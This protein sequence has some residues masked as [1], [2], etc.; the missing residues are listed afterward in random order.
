MMK[1]ERLEFRRFPV[2]GGAVFVST[3]HMPVAQRD[4]L[5]EEYELE[6]VGRRQLIAYIGENTG[7]KRF[8]EERR[9]Y[10]SE[11]R[12][13][14]QDIYLEL[15]IDMERWE[16]PVINTSRDGYKIGSRVTEFS[17]KVLLIGFEPHEP[18]E[19]DLELVRD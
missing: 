8:I 12:P 18:I 4:K 1:T 16:M 9:L 15:I 11:G 17:G 10:I 19:A 7:L 14:L 13:E 2:T 5:L 3:S 6:R